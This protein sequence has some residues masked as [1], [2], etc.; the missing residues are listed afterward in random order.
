MFISV[1]SIGCVD[2]SD[3]ASTAGIMQKILKQ[4]YLQRAY[5]TC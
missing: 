3:S 4:D 1:V 2:L 5:M